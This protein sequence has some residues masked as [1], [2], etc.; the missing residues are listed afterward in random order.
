MRIIVSYE[1]P[2]Y[3]P[4]EYKPHEVEEVSHWRTEIKGLDEIKPG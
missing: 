1:R 4:E 2:K 3:T